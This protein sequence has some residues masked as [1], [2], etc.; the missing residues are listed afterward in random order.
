MHIECYALRQI[1]VLSRIYAWGASHAPYMWTCSFGADYIYIC[2]YIH[3]YLSYIYIHTYMYI[4]LY[5]ST[6][7]Y[8]VY[9]FTYIHEYVRIFTCIFIYIYEYIR[10]YLCTCIYIW[11]STLGAEF[12]T[13]GIP[14]ISSV[15][16]RV[17]CESCHICMHETQDGEDAQDALSC[18]TLSAK[19]PLIVGLFCGKWPIK[20]R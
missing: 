10:I 18:R 2:I 6:Y 1:R 17:R 7:V 15:I 5:L 16:V 3:W 13:A 11:T 8:Y 14:S 20:I 4:H 12:K 19:E 9:P